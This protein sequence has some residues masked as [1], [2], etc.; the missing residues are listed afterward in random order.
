MAGQSID[1]RTLSNAAISY[2]K[3]PNEYRNK[4]KQPMYDE[5]QEFGAEYE[6]WLDDQPSFYDAP[7]ADEQ[8]AYEYDR[9]MKLLAG[10][11]I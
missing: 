11:L 10:G 6:Q 9:D 8:L 2:E 5:D 3:R 7:D 4:E 1:K